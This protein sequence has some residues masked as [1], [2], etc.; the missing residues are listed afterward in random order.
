MSHVYHVWLP[1]GSV[2]VPGWRLFF[3]HFARNWINKIIEAFDEQSSHPSLHLFVIFAW[4]KP[5]SF[6][7]CFHGI[8]YW[9]GFCGCCSGNMCRKESRK[10][11]RFPHGFPMVSNSK[12]IP[13]SSPS[14]MSWGCWVA[15]SPPHGYLRWDDGVKSPSQCFEKSPKK[16]NKHRTYRERERLLMFLCVFKCCLMLFDVVFCLRL[17]KNGWMLMAFLTGRDLLR[18]RWVGDFTQQGT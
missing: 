6:Q 14:S 15:S 9:I 17:M 1:E 7:C 8:E 2:P 12:A 5:W 11:N 13:T 3:F 4:I 10:T 18:P 16:I